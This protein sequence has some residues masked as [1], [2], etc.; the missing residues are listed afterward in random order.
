MEIVGEMQGAQ[1]KIWYKCTRCH[2]MAL[3]DLK[4]EAALKPSAKL[5]P[6]SAKIYNPELRF[7][8]GESIFHSEWNDVG[9]VVSRTKTSDGSES[10][11]VMFEKQ[12]ERRLNQNL[13]MEN[14][15]IF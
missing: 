4:L 14:L 12:G 7:N 8:I 13:K 3:I 6:A 10:I 2:H 15:S 5:D 11:V 1:E 9:R